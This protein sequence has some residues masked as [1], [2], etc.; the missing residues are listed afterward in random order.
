MGT[1]TETAITPPSRGSGRTLDIAYP[2]NIT[3][4]PGTAGMGT[5]WINRQAMSTFVVGG[6]TGVGAPPAGSGWTTYRGR[7]AYKQTGSTGPQTGGF[8]GTGGA[9]TF[10]I[11]FPQLRNGSS[12]YNDD[13][14]CWRVTA[15]LAVDAVTPAA[16]SGLE[17]GPAMNMDMISGT[18]AGF[19]LGP[20]DASL[21][22]ARISVRQTP[23][24]ALTVDQ[25]IN[26]I[27]VRDWHVYEMRF[28]GAT[29]TRDAVFKA[30]IDGT[31][32][33]TANWG[34]GTLLPDLTGLG[35]TTGYRITVGNRG[36]V[37]N[38]YLAMLGVTV[39]AAPSESALL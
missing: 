24:L 5:T 37:G 6:E 29:S 25:V 30:L 1:R 32:V 17:V 38:T 23:A 3:V 18:P 26:N 8:Y 14:R 27:D 9:T 12:G 15:I 7:I 28:I 2:Q 16:D 10:A 22:Q 4:V 33:F 36:I 35:G 19:R 31:Q 11:Y 34:A 20:S 21:T 39:S 13:Y